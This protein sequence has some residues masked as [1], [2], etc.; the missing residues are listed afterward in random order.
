MDFDSVNIVTVAL[1]IMGAILAT[2]SLE[3][4]IVL[5]A[6]IGHKRVLPVMTSTILP[7]LLLVMGFAWGVGIIPFLLWLV[8]VA[9]AAF[10]GAVYLVGFSIKRG[11]SGKS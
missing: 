1:V 7:L 9:I 11:I 8:V 6:G 2:S 10:L 4:I 5:C 3:F